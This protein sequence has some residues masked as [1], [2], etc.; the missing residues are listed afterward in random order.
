VTR[1]QVASHFLSKFEQHKVGSSAHIEYWIPSD[2]LISFNAAIHGMVHVETGFFDTAFIGHLPDSYG[3][4]GKNAIAQFIALHKTWAYS[5][6]DVACEVSANRKAIFLN[7]LFWRQHDFSQ[8]GVTAEQKEELLAN[9]K[10]CW[11]SNHTKVP[12]L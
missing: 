1:F 2:K 6:M 8:L 5:H 9:L 10:Q 3:L 12:L 4:K 7:W 11:E